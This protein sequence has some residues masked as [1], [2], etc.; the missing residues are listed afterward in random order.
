[1]LTA[2]FIIHDE[3]NY[4]TA[5]AFFDRNQLAK[6]TVIVLEGT[7]RFKSHVE[8]QDILHRDLLFLFVLYRKLVQSGVDFRCYS[9]IS[10]LYLPPLFW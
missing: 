7:N 8:F 2:L 3:G 5:Q 10:V 1:M 6:A 4:L 9:L